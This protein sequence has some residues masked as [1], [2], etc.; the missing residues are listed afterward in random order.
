MP[1]FTRKQLVML[2]LETTYGS[3]SAPTHTASYD[4]MRLIDP[5]VVDLGGEVVEFTGGNFTR[6]R[7]RPIS[8]V[9]PFGATFRTYVQGTDA[10]TYT[11]AVKPPIGAALQVCGLQE[12]FASSWAPQGRPTYLYYPT[13]DVSSDKSATMVINVDGFDHRAVGCRGNVN[14]IWSAAGPVI[15]EFT[16]RGILTTEAATTRAAPTGMPTATPQRWID[17]GSI[18]MGSLMPLVENIN[19]STNNTIFEERASIAS[20]ASGIAAIYLTE[21]AP[22][23]SFDPETTEP[24]S[25][26]ILGAW[27]STS[28]AILQLQAGIAQHLSFTITS[29]LVIPKQVTRADK[30]GLQIFNAQFESYERNGDDQFQIRFT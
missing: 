23:G 29:S 3:D 4:S 17:S 16:L 21:R 26:D 2:K 18:I 14:F 28:G 30:S 11:A 10:V 20:S 9:R 22:G 15:A 6:G 1:D 13:A 25:L 8:T 5:P 27:R 12:Q 19:F 24:T 7:I